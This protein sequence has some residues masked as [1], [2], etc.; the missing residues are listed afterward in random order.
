MELSLP[1]KSV[2]DILGASKGENIRRKLCYKT[3]HFVFKEK[4]VLK[5]YWQKLSTYK[6]GWVFVMM[7]ETK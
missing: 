5:D 2:Q 4:G 6:Q 1:K 7:R 3:V